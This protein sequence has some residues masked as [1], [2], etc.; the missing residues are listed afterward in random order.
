[1][2][3]STPAVK[4]SSAARPHDDSSRML[5]DESGASRATSKPDGAA[6]ATTNDTLNGQ[7]AS[8][9]AHQGTWLYASVVF[10]LHVST[11]QAHLALAS[12]HLSSAQPHAVMIR[13][14]IGLIVAGCASLLAIT[15]RS[16][17][18]GTHRPL[19]VA[20]YDYKRR[21]DICMVNMN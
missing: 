20:G 7:N 16:R 2:S 14:P 9:N 11:R 4:V 18:C 17:I 19:D 6:S 21:E 1:M 10:V 13:L 12:C 8:S 15:A 3:S 5:S